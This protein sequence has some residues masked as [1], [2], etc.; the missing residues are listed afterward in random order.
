MDQAMVVGLKEQDQ[1]RSNSKAEFVPFGSLLK[2]GCYSCYLAT[3]TTP[4]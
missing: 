4:A 3:Y 2:L 1:G